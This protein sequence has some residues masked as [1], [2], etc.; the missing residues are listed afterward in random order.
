MFT[1][2]EIVLV[3]GNTIGSQNTN[4][5][6]NEITNKLRLFHFTITIYPLCKK[7]SPCSH[8][9]HATTAEEGGVVW[10]VRWEKLV[11]TELTSNN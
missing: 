4:T 7:L 1:V 6:A 5:D 2:L 8:A 3:G 10:S 9:S 11:R